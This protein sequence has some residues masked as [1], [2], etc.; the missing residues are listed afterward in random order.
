MTTLPL[1]C[2][3]HGARSLEREHSF[4]LGSS[5]PRPNWFA[6]GPSLGQLSPPVSTPLCCALPLQD[7]RP[8]PYLRH[9]QPYTFD[10]NLSVA[11]KGTVM[12]LEDVSKGLVGTYAQV[13]LPG[14][15]LSYWGG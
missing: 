14:W 12:E 3:G 4:Y 11:L 1:Y 13:P 8:L 10:I 6:V 5:V 7:P 15:P 9:D 2:Q